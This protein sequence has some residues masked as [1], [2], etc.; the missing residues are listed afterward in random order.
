MAVCK[1]KLYLAQVESWARD[2][3]HCRQTPYR[4][5][6]ELLRHSISVFI[7]QLY[8]KQTTS[9]FVQC[10]ILI[11]TTLFGTKLWETNENIF[12][13]HLV[14][15]CSSQCKSVALGEYDNACMSCRPVVC[16][17]STVGCLSRPIKT[18]LFTV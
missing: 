3:L 8:L 4:P 2:L 1:Y 6:I 11:D 15:I 14:G 5:I 7:I 10:C 9:I 18:N 16:I 17:D 13:K 12:T